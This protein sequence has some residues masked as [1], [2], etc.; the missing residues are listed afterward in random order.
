[1]NGEDVN[2]YRKNDL[3]RILIAVMILVSRILVGLG[4]YGNA[5]HQLPRKTGRCSIAPV[6]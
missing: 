3:F 4:S 1:M 6:L 5:E 2:K